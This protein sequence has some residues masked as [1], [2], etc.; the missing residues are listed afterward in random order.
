MLK[1]ARPEGSVIVS[2]DSADL[3][4][5]ADA[6]EAFKPALP[7]ADQ[8]GEALAGVDISAL[9]RSWDPTQ[10]GSV[11]F[12]E[13]RM[14]VKGM[15][16]QHGFTGEI[17]SDEVKALFNSYDLDGSGI[18]DLSE[19][20]LMLQELRAVGSLRKLEREAARQQRLAEAAQLR[21]LAAQVDQAKALA[22]Q[23]DAREAA[24]QQLRQE[25]AC[26]IK[27]QLGMAFGRRRVRATDFV[28]QFATDARGMSR[29][30]FC[31]LAQSLIANLTAS[32]LS[33]VFASIDDDG[34]GYLDLPE[35]AAA[36]AS[37]QQHGTDK[38]LATEA[39]A[40]R[41]QYARKRADAQGRIVLL[42]LKSASDPSALSPGSISGSPSD[43]HQGH[44]ISQLSDNVGAS[45]ASRVRQRHVRKLA[46][47]AVKRLTNVQIS[48][49]L[50]AWLEFAEIRRSLMQ[51]IR[52]SLLHCVLR[53]VARAYA[54]WLDFY[55]YSLY[56]RQLMSD[57]WHNLRASQLTRAF[58]R[59]GAACLIVVPPTLGA[60]IALP[61]PL[62]LSQTHAS[63]E[64]GLCQ[65]IHA[66][67]AQAVGSKQG[68]SKGIGFERG[69]C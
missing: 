18:I 8:V 1:R 20:I 9:V 64:Q 48:M 49:A 17:N 16:V 36:V 47:N 11:I 44:T 27:A 40:R 15:A 41:A 2:V 53:D 31:K 6:L 67:M 28:G 46:K 39:H 59:W 42:A 60:G 25:F 65:A 32:E 69:P 33:P 4:A 45:T 26:D 52:L 13:F 50:N 37:M 22:A 29:T 38:T 19:L 14:R 35:A 51:V 43:L 23:A 56:M 34:S 66:C 57:S 58:R 12:S 62:P 61:P 24:L 10:S 63:E 68:Q 7:V 21:Q 5:Q 3:T 55:E 54:T 30:D